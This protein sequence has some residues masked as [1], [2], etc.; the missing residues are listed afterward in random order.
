MKFNPILFLS[1]A[2]LISFS[3][4]KS[5]LNPHCWG[6]REEAIFTSNS[7]GLRQGVVMLKDSSR[8]EVLHNVPREFKTGDP[9][10]V[11]I[12]YKHTDDFNPKDN[13]VQF[14]AI[15]IQCIQKR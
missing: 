6:D 13:C 9:V 15:K 14:K 7:C 5:K 3:C 2:L 8:Y 11:Y 10:K 1:I 4:K 12:K